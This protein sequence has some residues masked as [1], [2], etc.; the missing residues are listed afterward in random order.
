MKY[1]NIH[2][3]P[4]PVRLWLEEDTYD[5][6]PGIYSATR[7]MKPV[8]MV[9]LEDRHQAELVMDISEEIAKRYGTALHESFE[10][11][12]IPDSRQEERK[13]ADISGQRISGKPDLIIKNKD[14]TESIWDIKST[15]VW[16]FIYGKRDAEHKLQV[17]IYRLLE[18]LNGSDISEQGYIIYLFT[19]WSKSRARQNS[20]YPNTRVVVKEMELHST[21]E[22]TKY[23]E[24]RLAEFQ[25]HADSPE[26]ELPYCTREELWQED[27]KWAVM[28]EGR[29][30]AVKLH[31]TEEAAL[32]HLN[33]LDGPFSIVHRPGKVNRCD[34]CLV[35]PFCSQ[36]KELKK[37]GLIPEE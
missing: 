13:F 9:I 24:S 5:Y 37:A 28:K 7:L 29:K 25:L 35:T 30:S 1:T 3:L 20:D 11:V 2:K 26:P 27:D 17:S 34:Y 6:H 33:E 32:D 18:I 14:G 16:T 36:Y 4:E 31:D 23:I 19:D 22:T 10:K 8:R 21:E 12:P 15:S